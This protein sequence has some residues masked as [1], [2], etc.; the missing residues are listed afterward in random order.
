LLGRRV[1]GDPELEQ[2]A[3]ACIDHHVK[4][5]SNASKR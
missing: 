2:V 5:A 4:T 1:L 3:Q